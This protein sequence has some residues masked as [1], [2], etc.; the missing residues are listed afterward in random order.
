MTDDG[1]PP[2]EPGSVEDRLRWVAKSRFTE[3]VLA[4][5]AD[6][7]LADDLAEITGGERTEDLPEA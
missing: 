1:R 3:V 2:A 6:P 7:G 4:A 5:Q